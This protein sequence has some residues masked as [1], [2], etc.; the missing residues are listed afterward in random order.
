MRT[1]I[2]VLSFTL[3]GSVFGQTYR[4]EAVANPSTSGSIQPNWSV[5]PDGSPLLSW[6][7]PSKN[8][9]LTLRYA[10][11]RGKAWSEPHTVAADRH[12]FR[13]PAEVPE[14]MQLNDH[15]WMAHWVEMPNEANEAEFVW[16]SSSTDG[17]H[18][19]A[20]LMAHKDHGQ[21]EHGLASMAA[22]AKGE[23]SV[24]W[25]EQPKGEDGP[26]YLMRTVLDNSGKEV[27]EERLDPDVCDCCPTAATRTAKGLLV[28]YRSRTPQ[29]IRDISIIRLESG[30]WSSS[31]VIHADGW[32]IN[33]C[34]TN[35][36]SVSAKGDK[37][38]VAWFTAA[39]NKPRVQI[40][41]SSDSGA[42]FGNATVVSTGHAF[43]YTSVALADDGSALVSWLEDGPN[44]TRVL[45]RAVTPAGAAG[46]VI[47]VAEGGR[48]ALGYPRVVQTAAGSF[49]SLAGGKS[50]AK[51]QTFRLAK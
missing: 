2:L 35:A 50:G 27:R 48:T 39:Q 26:G 25:L 11:W 4:A 33:A 42:T 24:L 49:I 5:T 30:K 1:S 37:V 40:S 20:P 44:A 17:V 21:V 10:V 18:W 46:P 15:L 31:K 23:I 41:F 19:T 51:I 36:A 16:A 45:A 34:P 3:A 14:V 6:V 9:A 29:D 28:A 43:G 38:A 7:E 8:G 22:D 12:F 47:Q 32:H 13:H